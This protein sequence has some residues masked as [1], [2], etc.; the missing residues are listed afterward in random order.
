[1]FILFGTRKEKQCPN[2]TVQ[3]TAFSFKY[4]KTIENQISMKNLDRGKEYFALNY[5]DTYLKEHTAYVNFYLIYNV[6]T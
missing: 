2:I 5:F 3:Y 4:R 6:N 1:M